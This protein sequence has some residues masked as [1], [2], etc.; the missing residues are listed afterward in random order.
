[1]ATDVIKSHTNAN[2]SSRLR[3]LQ[4]PVARSHYPMSKILQNPP[5]PFSLCSLYPPTFPTS[6]SLPL[7][8]DN[9][10]SIKYHFP[11][12]PSK[13]TPGPLP[14]LVTALFSCLPSKPNL[15]LLISNTCLP[16]TLQVP[17]LTGVYSPSIWG[18]GSSHIFLVPG[19]PQA[20]HYQVSIL[21]PGPS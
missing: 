6:L 18:S 1:M 4:D 8:N 7:F 11:L 21:N 5:L 10:S 20:V 2:A 12:P 15:T 9:Q 16:F 19:S 3:G 14:C 17:C 13:P